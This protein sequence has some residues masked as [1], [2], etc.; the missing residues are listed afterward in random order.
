MLRKLYTTF[1]EIQY[2]DKQ[3]NLQQELSYELIQGQTKQP[4]IR[5]RKKIKL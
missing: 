1:Q 3:H 5:K 2:N 4:L